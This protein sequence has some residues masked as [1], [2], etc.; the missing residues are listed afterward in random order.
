MSLLMLFNSKP[1][2]AEIKMKSRNGE[3]EAVLSTGKVSLPVDGN[4]FG[5][6][7]Y[8]CNFESG[9]VKLWDDELE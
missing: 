9:K 7:Y 5:T 1:D 4:N 2:L 6:V 8:Y 3:M